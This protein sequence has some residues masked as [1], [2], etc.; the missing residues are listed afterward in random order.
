MMGQ[1]RHG[2]PHNLVAWQINLMLTLV[3]E[4][5]QGLAM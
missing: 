4:S 3:I 2:Y 5:T 1:T